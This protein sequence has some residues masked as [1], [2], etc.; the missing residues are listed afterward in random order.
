MLPMADGTNYRRFVDILTSIQRCLRLRGAMF[1]RAR[2][3]Q[4]YRRAGSRVDPLDDV[5]IRKGARLRRTVL[6]ME[7][8]CL[9]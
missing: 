8:W 9:Q 1:S 3:S 5:V 7:L 4:L 2:T 6:A